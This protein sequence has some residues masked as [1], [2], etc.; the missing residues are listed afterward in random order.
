MPDLS[1]LVLKQADIDLLVA[2]QAASK[3][4]TATRE[5]MLRAAQILSRLGLLTLIQFGLLIYRPLEDQREFFGELEV[6]G[7]LAQIKGTAGW[8]FNPVGKAVEA[9]GAAAGSAA[10]S[11]LQGIGIV[12]AAFF[13]LVVLLLLLFF[14]LRSG[15]SAK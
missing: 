15:G 13:G 4:G 2:V 7:K 1:E 5:E 8:V 6:I 12:V 14:G 10:G 11:L 3:A 9:G